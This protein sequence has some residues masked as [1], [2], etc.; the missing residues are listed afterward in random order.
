VLAAPVECRPS[1]KYRERTRRRGR[2][3]LVRAGTSGPNFLRLEVSGLFFFV[4]G[5]TRPR[6]KTTRASRTGKMH[7]QR[8]TRWAV[9]AISGVLDPVSDLRSKGPCQ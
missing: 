7:E 2:P 1:Q 8:A 4:A 3:G 9:S 6:S 5:A